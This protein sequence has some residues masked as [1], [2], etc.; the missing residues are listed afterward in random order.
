MNKQYINIGI[1]GL[2]IHDSDELKNKINNIL[3]HHLNVQWKTASDINLDCLFI[4]EQF[5]ETEGIQRILN[6]KNFPWLKIAKNNTLS[7]TVKNNTLYLPIEDTYELNHW[8]DQNILHLNQN[9]TEENIDLIPIINKKLP[10]NHIYTE[11]YF[12]AMSSN[13]SNVKLHLSDHQG[14]IAVIDSSKNLT[15]LNPHHSAYQTDFSFKYDLASTN[16]LLKVSRKESLILQDW[17][18][19]LFWNSSDFYQIAPEDGHYKILFWPKPDDSFNRKKIFQMSACFIQGAKMSK[20]SEQH[21]IPILMIRRFIAANMATGNLEKI[22]VWDKHYTPPARTEKTEEQ[23]F[24][25]S[26]L[27]KIRIKFGF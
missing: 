7:G 3:P 25:K 26:F 18:W 14:S 22:N 10:T 6:T 21:D 19:N 27:G 11:S 16:D 5:F 2:S 4:H 15:W 8:I 23:N 20:I 12:K 17:L 9:N 1:S 24:I 13:T